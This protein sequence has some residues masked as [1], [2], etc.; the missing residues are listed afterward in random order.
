M[1]RLEQL[2]LQD[3]EALRLVLLGTSVIDWQRLAFTERSDVDHFLSLCQF[4]PESAADQVWMRGII[5]DAVKYLRETFRYRI[6]D[7]VTKLK[8][9][10]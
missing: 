4:N 7:A 9:D 1:R 10:L 3:V 8:D 2:K 5:N 6:P